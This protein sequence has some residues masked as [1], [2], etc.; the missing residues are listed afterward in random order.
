MILAFFVLL[1][2]SIGVVSAAEN[3]DSNGI[4]HDN[5]VSDSV[6][7]SENFV[8][9]VGTG[10]TNGTDDGNGTG[11]TNGTDDGNGTNSSY[12]INVPKSTNVNLDIKNVSFDFNITDENGTVIDVDK[13]DLELKFIFPHA[14]SANNIV[15]EIVMIENYTI[16]EG[17]LSF[18]IKDYANLT[19]AGLLQIRYKN[20]NMYTVSVVPVIEAEIRV[21]NNESSTK[22]QNNYIVVQLWNNVTNQ[23]IVGKHLYFQFLNSS[24]GIRWGYT[25]DKYGKCNISLDSLY[26]TSSYVPVGKFYKLIITSEDRILATGKNCTINITKASGVLSANNF[27]ATYGAGKK[28]L[29]TLKNS[30]TKK[31]INYSK[32]KLRVYFSSKSYSDFYAYTNG[33]GVSSFGINLGAGKYKVI[34]YCVDGNVSASSITRYITVTKVSAKL[35]SSKVT[36]YY[37]SPKYFTVKMINSKTGKSL[38]GAPILLN[39]Y[40]GKKFKVVKLTTDDKGIAKWK[41]SGISAGSHIVY[42]GSGS[43]SAKA[44]VIKSSIKLYKAQTTVY[45]PKVINKYKASK[46]F[47]VKITNKNTKKVVSSLTLKIKVYTGKKYKTYTVKTNSKGIVNLNTK[48]LSKG[49][50][51]VVIKSGNTNYSVSRSGYLIAIKR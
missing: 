7:W 3:F 5:N 37:A 33:S 48:Y 19:G 44:N 25:T 2:L 43:N 11:G 16:S 40:T 47:K 35:S 21:L 36:A 41:I 15:D 27:S 38:V 49:T 20:G 8:S 6:V 28:L 31:S 39:V 45:A 17:K 22:Y 42:I 9:E 30:N 24:L 26:Y 34:I 51:K 4:T 1:V 14:D 50:H 23:P 32:L 12:I 46:Y 13:A 10:G 18:S 29:I